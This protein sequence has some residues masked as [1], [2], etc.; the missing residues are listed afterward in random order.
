[1]TPSID[2]LIVDDSAICRQN[3]RTIVEGDGDLRVAG[4][5]KCGS[6]VLRALA[7]V[8]PRVLLTDLVMPETDGIAVVRQVMAHHPIPIIVV[9]GGG[10]GES[11]A[12]EAIR[13]GALEV[14]TKPAP[15]DRTAAA[16]LRQAIRRLAGVRVVRHPGLPS[17]SP[18][19]TV[20]AKPPVWHGP[21][22]RVLGI[23]AS[24]GGPSAIVELV[25]ELDP[26]QAP[27]VVVAQHLPRGQSEGFARFLA[28]RCRL[29]VVLCKGTTSLGPGRLVLPGDGFH[30][31]V[32][33]AGR[34]TV[35]EPDAGTLLVPSVDLLFTSL[36]MRVGAAAVGVVLTGIG[37]D[38]ALGLAALRDGGALTLAQDEASS[39]VYGMP[40]AAAS[41]ALFHL[42]PREMARMITGVFE[43]PMATGEA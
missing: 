12:F 22:P 43:R 39:A 19:T 24:A 5:V 10:V 29:E 28:E 38:G 27:A 4:E 17:T 25:A 6:D 8:Q 31:V 15:G 23:G 34:A 30:L 13:S 20:A 9:S 33:D 3:L 41:A 26:K 21:R 42:P 18:G 35:T 16:T 32:L 1:M 40:R 36:A 11:A 2:V 14:A 7:T 37:H